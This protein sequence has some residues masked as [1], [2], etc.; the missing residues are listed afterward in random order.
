M[1]VRRKIVI[2]D[3]RNMSGRREKVC[4]EFFN[5]LVREREDNEKKE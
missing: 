3:V 1:C 5:G 4:A 2:T